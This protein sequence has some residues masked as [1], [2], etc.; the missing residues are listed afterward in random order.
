MKNYRR[1][2]L[3]PGNGSTKSHYIIDNKPQAVLVTNT[4]NRPQY[5]QFQLT[6]EE[7]NEV[8]MKRAAAAV[9]ANNQQQQQQQQQ[10]QSH[11][12]LDS[13]DPSNAAIQVQVQKV[14]QGLEESDDQ[15]SIPTP[16]T[17]T[18]TTTEAQRN[19]CKIEADLTPK[20]ETQTVEVITH[21]S[22]IEQEVQEEHEVDEQSLGALEI[23][24][25]ESPPVQHNKER[26]YS[27]EQCGKSFVLK[28][29]LTTHIR[30]HTG[31]FFGTFFDHYS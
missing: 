21:A 12:S 6:P 20:V 2:V 24:K 28:H 5:T 19:P 17:I 4:G 9:A 7:Y 18:T 8:L 29:H 15:Q 14:I 22:H 11:T 16:T 31:E 30:V 1:I 10:P 26:P 3:G 23:A 27:C 25:E 13:N